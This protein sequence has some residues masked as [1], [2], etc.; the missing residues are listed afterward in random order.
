MAEP[1]SIPP[2]SPRPPNAWP[3]DEQQQQQQQPRQNLAKGSASPQRRGSEEQSATKQNRFFP[4]SLTTGDAQPVQ[5]RGAPV[6]GRAGGRPPVT[7]AVGTQRPVSYHPGTS[8]T[9]YGTIETESGGSGDVERQASGAG[10]GTGAGNGS[11]INLQG[12]SYRFQTTHPDHSNHVVP[13]SYTATSGT[14]R[15]S[16]AFLAGMALNADDDDGDDDDD[17]EGLTAASPRSAASRDRYDGGQREVLQGDG[18]SSHDFAPISILSQSHQSTGPS[19]LSKA[20]SAS[21]STSPSTVKAQDDS[22]GEST[23]LLGAP[24]GRTPASPLSG[25]GAVLEAE[26]EAKKRESSQESSAPSR[27]NDRAATDSGFSQRSQRS[28]GGAPTTGAGS[29]DK[30]GSSSTYGYGVLAQAQQQEEDAKLMRTQTQSTS[31]P[32][33]VSFAD[34]SSGPRP[35]PRYEYTDDDDDDG[36]DHGDDEDEDG[37]QEDS[38]LSPKWAY[39]PVW[40]R[41]GRGRI[42]V[43]SSSPSLGLSTVYHAARKLTWRDAISASAE[44]IRLLPAVILGMLLNVLD[45]VSYG[46]IIFPTSYPIFADFGGDGVSMFFV[47]CIISQLVYTLGGSIFKG[48]NGSMMIE[49]VPFYHILVTIIIDTLG[50]EADPASVVSTTIVAFALSSIFAGIVFMLLGYFRLGVLVGFFPR[51]ILVGCIGGVGVFLIETGLEVSSQL[52][53][54]AGF[55]WNLETFKFFTQSWFMVAHWLP[56]LFLAILLRL[57]TAKWHQPL[58]F[59]TYFLVI[60]VIF[61]IITSGIL[62]VPLDTLRR[63]DWVFDVGKAAEAPFWRFYTYFDFSKTSLAALWATMPTQLALTFFSILHVPLN[64]PALAISVNEDNLDTDRELVAHGIS[65]I[66]AGLAGSVPNYLCYVNSVLFYRV[67]GGSRLSGLML[68]AGTFAILLA[69]PGAIGYLP[70]YV[71][72]ALIFVLG[73]DLTKEAV[74]DTIGRVNGWEYFTI[75]LIIFVMTYYD[76]VVGILAG[77]IVACLFFVIQT[78]RRRTVRAVLDGS[79]A[80]ST[81]RRHITQRRFLE[82]VGSQTQIVKLQGFLYFANISSVEEL[83]RRALDIATWQSHPIRFLVVDFSLVNGVDFS[84]AEAF[85]RIQRLL[86]AKDVVLVFC[87][88]TPDSDVGV[89]LR[90]VDLWAESSVRVEVFQNLNEALEWSENEYLRGMYAAAAA[91]SQ[92]PS[93]SSTTSSGGVPNP[94]TAAMHEATATGGGP[95]GLEVPRGGPRRAP[96]FSLEESTVSSPRREHLHLAAKEAAE[97]SRRTAEMMTKALDLGSLDGSQIS[98]TESTR[99]GSEV[100]LEASK[101]Q[102]LQTQQVQAQSRVQQ[103][104]QQGRR[105]SS[106]ATSGNANHRKSAAKSVHFSSHQPLPLLMVTFQAYTTPPYDDEV[107]FRRITPFFTRLELPAGTTL[108]ERDEEPDGLYLIERGILKARYDF[109]QEDYEI[110]EA[111]LAGTIAGELSF[112]AQQ[113]RNTTAFAE[114][115]CVLWKLDEDAVERMRQS[116]DGELFAP[117]LKMLLKACSEEQE[118]LMSY[119]VSRLS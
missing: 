63:D 70:I 92:R 24:R 35:R 114:L 57:I 14:I 100:S 1:Q 21:Q 51:H 15:G 53:S 116:G 28:N 88:L 85:T 11:D 44:P 59:P 13:S 81:V 33:R 17:N 10:A 43:T 73:L 32:R 46:L 41:P 71:V 65:N 34:H 50:D 3:P 91:V 16:T 117:F 27:S 96:A 84:A 93:L 60:P 68:A 40:F 99:S 87:G 4:R 9:G 113:R 38:E 5:G 56:P 61:Y 74:W 22:P 89:A 115:D 80:R 62:R 105:R 36:D 37:Y 8:G 23:P 19:N 42:P 30:A 2:S 86:Q 77:I 112:L 103:Q 39:V 106:V 6:A 95:A 102:Q 45:G 55:Q 12:R 18:A 111:M 98:T 104:Q 67:G 90:S 31:G 69:G 25:A 94:P 72:G 83:I 66:L 101:E 110:N 75:W 79:I 7:A 58:I 107:F 82:R 78:S 47:T 108:W 54:E 64:V 119:L 20:I 29:F 52:K 49:V 48:G 109:P 97:R 118:G 76:F 26:E